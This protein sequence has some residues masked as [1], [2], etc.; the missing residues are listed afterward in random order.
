MGLK[1]PKH[2]TGCLAIVVSRSSSLGARSFL[3]HFELASLLLLT[4]MT[5]VAHKSGDYKGYH[6]I[7]CYRVIVLLSAYLM[8][9]LHRDGCL[10]RSTRD[11]RLCLC[12]EAS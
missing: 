2:P 1:L 6:M 11:A 8:G 5:A 3:S 9:T 10:T 4:N 12:I 7:V